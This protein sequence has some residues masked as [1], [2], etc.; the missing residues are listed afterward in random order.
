MDLSTLLQLLNE[1]GRFDD[2]AGNNV[3]QFGTP[4]RQYL[5]AR[6]MPERPAD[7]QGREDGIRYKTVV[8]SAGTRFSTA[9]KKRQ[10]AMVGGFRYELGNSDIERDLTAQDYDAVVNYLGRGGQNFQRSAVETLLDFSDAA[11]NRALVEFN[12]IQRWQYWETGQ[13]TILLPRGGQETV[14]YPQPDGGGHRLTAGGT[15][16]DD[17]YDAIADIERA[18]DV[19]RDKGY[20]IAQIVLSNNILRILS[21]RED[22]RALGGDAVMI[23]DDTNAAGFSIAAF[24]ANRRVVANAFDALGLPAPLRYDLRYNTQTS[25]NRFLSDDTIVFFG[26]STTERERIVNNQNA[27]DVRYLPNTLGYVGVGTAAGQSTPGRVID[28]EEFTNKPPRVQMEGWQ[29]SLPIPQ[30]PEAVASISGIA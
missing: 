7:N 14:Q 23:P 25:T 28:V 15:Y 9:T 27:E 20:D 11:V 6:F 21:R 5:G 29:T 26:Q 18:A 13:V 24:R 19:L 4:N 3:A 2:I 16:S 17:A 12:E 1:Q 30:E 10:G 8:A 22:I